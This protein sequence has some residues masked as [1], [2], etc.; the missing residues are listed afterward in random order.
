MCENAIMETLKVAETW[1]A[2]Q[3]MERLTAKETAVENVATKQAEA[4]ALQVTAAAANVAAIAQAAITGG[5]IQAAMAPGAMSASIATFGG[6]AAEGGAAYEG[7]MAV[8]SMTSF[9][10]GTP[11]VPHD[12]VAQIH[13]NEMI[14]PATMADAVRKGDMTL[15]GSGSGEGSSHSATLA[16][17]SDIMA[18]VARNGHALVKVF[19]NHGR[20]AFA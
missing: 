1:V 2:K 3:I 18:V 12:M 20:V 5:A 13:K 17:D 14:V 15:G 6:A 10:V 4:A 8:A 16:L 19:N 7:M 9:D 11:R